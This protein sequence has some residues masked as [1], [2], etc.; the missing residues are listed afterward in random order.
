MPILISFYMVFRALNYIKDTNA[1]QIMLGRNHHRQLIVHSLIFYSIWF[2]LWIPWII[3]TYLDIDDKNALI[4]Y[5]SLVASTIQI[6]ANP[7]LAFFLDKRFAQAWKTS[8]KWI[9][10]QLGCLLHNRVHPAVELG[11]V[12]EH[13]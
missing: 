4:V 9:Q 6:V 1:Q 7:M 12:R 10:R 8:V 13:P 3:V 11:A 5:V 2:I